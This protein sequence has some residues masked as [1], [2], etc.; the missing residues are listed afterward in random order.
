M[1]KL[2]P[3]SVVNL[4]SQAVIYD[5]NGMLANNHLKKVYQAISLKRVVMGLLASNGN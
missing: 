4:V 2:G 5:L 1:K 3:T